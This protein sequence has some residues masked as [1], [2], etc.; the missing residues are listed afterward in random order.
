M[1]GVHIVPSLFLDLLK[2]IQQESLK[3]ALKSSQSCFQVLVLSCLK[4][5]AKLFQCCLK[6]VSELFQSCLKVLPQ[7]TLLLDLLKV[8][9]LSQTNSNSNKATVDET[10]NK[11]QVTL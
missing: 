10:S 5:L 1:V 4:V 9:Q 8:I 6:V 11:Q 7:V 3:V 2:V